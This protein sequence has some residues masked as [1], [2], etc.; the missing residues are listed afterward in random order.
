M[1]DPNFLKNKATGEIIEEGQTITRVERGCNTEYKFVRIEDERIVVQRFNK[2]SYGPEQVRRPESFGCFIWNRHANWING[3]LV[4]EDTPDTFNILREIFDLGSN[5]FKTENDLMRGAL[6]P[7]SP[8]VRA[9]KEMGENVPTLKDFGI[10][11]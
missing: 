8:F 5:P 10:D 3:Q 1:T 11:E 4:I 7:N 2:R 9:L 6:D